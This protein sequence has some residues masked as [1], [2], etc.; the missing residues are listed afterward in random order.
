MCSYKICSRFLFELNSIYCPLFNRNNSISI[1]DPFSDGSDP[2]FQKRTLLSSGGPYQS[3]MNMDPMMRMQF[4]N[5]DHFAGMRKGW[6]FTFVNL[7]LILH[8]YFCSQSNILIPSESSSTNLLRLY[9]SIPL[10][11]ISSPS[12]K[13]SPSPSPSVF[14]FTLLYFCF[15]LWYYL[16]SSLF[17]L[18]IF[19]LVWGIIFWR[20][21]PPSG[22][23]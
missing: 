14:H 23:H 18:C 1:Q 13:C 4:E 9:L 7:I 8:S 21:L 17:H 12:F 3:S 16:P 11:L 10:F 5:K 6:C 20:L 22:Q 15:F 19:Y 2:A